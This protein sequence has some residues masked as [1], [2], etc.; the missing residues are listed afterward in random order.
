[1]GRRRGGPRSRPRALGAP[2]GC[3]QPDGRWWGV[4]APLYALR[5]ED[6]WGVGSFSELATFRGWVER[7]GGSVAATLPLFAQF[8]DEPMVEPSPYSPA[9]R[10]FWNETY[11]DLTRVPGLDGCEEA[12]EA[13]DDPSFGE[14]LARLREERAL[15]PSGGRRGEAAC[16]R[17]RRP[18][19]CS[20]ARSRPGWKRSRPILGPRTTR[21]SARR[22]SDAARGGA[23]GRGRNER[24]RSPGR[25]STTTG[26]ATTSSSSGWRPSSCRRPPAVRARPAG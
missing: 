11:I 23:R 7:L 17:P 13:L 9:S 25:R 16:P 15:R 26:R 14:Q 4:F 8:L 2:E 24:A 20:G 12:R 19:R 22:W 6:D 5:A 1:M 10:L 3:P 18:S 21:G